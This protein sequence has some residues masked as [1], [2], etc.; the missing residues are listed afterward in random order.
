MFGG[1]LTYSPDQATPGTVSEHHM[2]WTVGSNVFTGAG[3]NGQVVDTSFRYNTQLNQLDA[4]AAV[5]DF[6]GTTTDNKTVNGFGTAIT[7][8]DTYTPWRSLTLQ[9]RYGR[10][11]PNFNTPQRSGQYNNQQSVSFGANYRVNEHLT[12]GGFASRGDSLTSLTGTG[13]RTRSYNLNATY[14]PAQ[15]YLPRITVTHAS[16]TTPLGNFTVTQVN[17][18]RDF[19]RWRPFINYTLARGTNQKANALTVGSSFI[20]Q[21]FGTFQAVQS[22]GG[23]KTGS[24][25]WYPTRP[26]V[27]GVQISAGAGYAATN[28]STTPLARLM[29]IV[30]LPRRQTLQVSY[31]RTQTNSE[32]RWTMTGPLD[33]WRKKD[34]VSRSGSPTIITDS[35]IQGRIYQD[36]NRDNQFDDR[37]D[38]PTRGVT[39]LL[40]N[41]NTTVT[42]QQGHYR[43]DRVSP[44][45]H[46]VSISLYDVRA[47]LIPASSLQQTVS[48]SPRRIV[49]SDFR[50]LKSG[51]V[52]GRIWRDTNGNGQYDEGEVALSNIRIVSSSGR[53]T[54][55]DID[56]TFLLS[57]LPSGEQIIFLDQRTLPRD[58][59]ATATQLQAEVRPGQETTGIN[60]IF[61]P[62]SRPV[63]EKQFPGNESAQPS[64]P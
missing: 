32:T 53:D 26:L 16:L 36:V 23:G 39:V 35:T 60:F 7:V 33:F 17:L 56:G 2:V 3:Q 18:S 20:T 11:S 51:R 46:T 30:R 15:R 5:G 14:D 24:F 55:T 34:D 31:T 8:G 25:D 48:L 28:G 45:I 38:I 21:R 54:Y 61:K 29:A 10:F 44:G 64:K 12:F 9:G 19:P 59:L 63:Q 42:D 49:T 43:F 57:D 40:D 13:H 22:V 58:L 62:R 37:V 1:Q 41:T 47:D 4:E 52:S 27:G 6:H 50:L